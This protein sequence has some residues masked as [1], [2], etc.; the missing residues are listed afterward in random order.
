MDRFNPPYRMDRNVN[1][2]GIALYI[3]KD[4]TSTLLHKVTLH[5][6]TQSNFGGNT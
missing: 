6:V 4:I 1:E 3:R 2:G 5:K